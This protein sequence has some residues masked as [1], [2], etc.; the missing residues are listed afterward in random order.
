MSTTTFQDGRSD[1]TFPTNNN[2]YK[3]TLKYHKILEKS[4]RNIQNVRNTE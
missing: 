3:G 4:A 2:V 1:V